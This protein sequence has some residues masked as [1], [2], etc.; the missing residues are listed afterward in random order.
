MDHPK[1]RNKSNINKPTKMNFYVQYKVLKQNKYPKTYI[2]APIKELCS[3]QSFG[4]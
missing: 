3:V 2:P 4:S 1:Q